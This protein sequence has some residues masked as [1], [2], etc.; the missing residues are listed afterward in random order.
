LSSLLRLYLRVE[1]AT[2]EDTEATRVDTLVTLE[3]TEENMEII[4]VAFMD[5]AQLAQRGLVT[6]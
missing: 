4:P 5:G 6:S 3:A 2:A 1:E